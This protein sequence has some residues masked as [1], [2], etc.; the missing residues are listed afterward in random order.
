MRWALRPPYIGL[1]IALSIA[2]LPSA[3]RAADL[4]SLTSVQ[5]GGAQISDGTTV[6]RDDFTSVS[7]FWSFNFTWP[8]SVT[9]N[10]SI[11]AVF[12]G[13]FGSVDGGTIKS[14]VN[15]SSQ[16]ESVS[17]GVNSITKQFS[18]PPDLGSLAHGPGVYTAVVAEL[19]QTA[20]MY[21]DFP[22]W[23]KSGGVQGVGPVQY[24]TLT[25][26]YEPT[27]NPMYLPNAVHSVVVAEREVLDDEAVYR[28]EL[29]TLNG[30]TDHHWRFKFNWPNSVPNQQ[31]LF[32]I[33]RGTFGNI[34]GG[35]PIENVNYGYNSQ[36][37]SSGENDVAKFIGLPPLQHSST[38]SSAHTV[39]IA[40]RDPKFLAEG[41]DEQAL[42]FSSGGIQGIGPL[43]YSLLSFEFKSDDP[44]PVVIVP[45]I[46]GSAQNENGKWVLDPITHIYD[47]LYETLD[48]NW[49]SPE[50]NLYTF[51]YDWRKSNVDTA[52]LLRDKI[53]E[54]QEICHCRKVDLVAHS[55]GGLVSRQYIQSDYY[56]DD[57]NNM[58]FLGTPHLGAPKAYL[59]WEAGNFDS[60]AQSLILK[61]ILTL[62]A[63]ENGYANLFQYIRNNPIPS[64]QQLL[65]VYSYLFDEA[66]QLKVYPQEYPTNQF[67]EDLKNDLP[68]LAS[69]VAKVTN[70]VG[71]TAQNDTIVSLQV[72]E[73]SVPPFW[74]DGM[75]VGLFDIFGYSGIDRGVGDGTV[76]KTSAE[77]VATTSN[78]FVSNHADLPTVAEADVYFDL[79]NQ[80]AEELVNVNPF[81]RFLMFSIFSPADLTITD[82]QGRRVGREGSGVVNE[83]PGAYYTGFNTNAEFI[84]IPDPLDGE[85]KVKALGAEEG[86]EFRVSAS[87]VTNGAVIEDDYTGN[88]SPGEVD[89][90]I[91]QF[92]QSLPNSIDIH[93]L[94]EMPPVIVINTPSTHDYLHSEV[95]DLDYEVVDLDSGV[96]STT[97]TLDGQPVLD[98]VDLFFQSLGD[99]IS[100]I[101]AEDM[102]GNIA[103]SSVTFRVI[104]TPESTIQDVERSYSLGWITREQTK[105]LLIQMLKKATKVK[106]KIEYIEETLP[107][108]T[109]KQKKIEKLETW[110]DKLLGKKVLA[111]LQ[112]QLKSKNITQQAYDTLRA[113][114]E[115]ILEHL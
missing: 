58:I 31:T 34:E 40:E 3:A 97:I 110:F 79:T 22:L 14:G 49:Y 35:A 16:A 27:S 67:L 48:V 9:S 7:Q 88:V 10:K 4:H 23:F 73:S 20:T 95:I 77:A 11:F 70:F 91:A 89:E 113:D 85:Y 96:E 61:G 30:S 28:K 106:K 101:E 71:Q 111:E 108:G 69:R 32:M 41:V 24:S 53:D 87:Y 104:A 45:G 64:V 44:Y 38:T 29:A 6:T 86:G 115:W 66:S 1:L 99:H 47:N 15:Y 103:S 105:N 78:T 72:K 63:F 50:E 56:E 102:V 46:L 81:K 19:N 52:F 60:D 57:V 8:N 100:T 112:K 54:I 75:P 76:P 55:M 92:D 109:K 42:W 51:P 62:E 114:V 98:P 25:F 90:S 65:P 17:S 2:F 94:D 39:M 68:L 13:T 12:R 43:K 33:F 82:P 74:P 80:T 36:I 107:D 84:V 18:L 37:W 83:V 26:T 93:A 5:V 21:T 59:M